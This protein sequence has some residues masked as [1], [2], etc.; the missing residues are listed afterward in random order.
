MKAY[1]DSAGHIRLFRPMMNMERLAKSASRLALPAFDK[2]GL[3][4]CVEEL[5]KL[6]HSWIPQEKGYSL[7]IRP[8]MIATQETLGVAASDR[9]LL[10]VILSP[11]GPY[12]KTGFAAVS[13]LANEKH[14]R[15][16]PGGTG[17]HKV[18]GNYAPCILPQRE[19]SERGYQQNLWLFGP[20]HEITEVGTMN[21]FILWENEN[22]GEWM[23]V[24]CWILDVGC[25]KGN[26]WML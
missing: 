7:Y 26:S 24:R 20:D 18:G 12:Y 25:W 15:A 4:E 9:A 6:D 5:V 16:W 1:K 11:V 23:D 8:T 21:C 3:L 10:F 17:S 22:H 2:G 13:L 19:A 14:V